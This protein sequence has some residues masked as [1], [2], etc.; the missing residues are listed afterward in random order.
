MPA[1]EEQNVSLNRTHAI[2]NPIGAGTDLL[3]G[4]ASRTTVA[5]QIPSWAFGADIGAP[6]S[7]ILA[8]VP[9]NKIR[10]YLGHGAKSGEFARSARTLQ[11]TREHLFEL[12]PFKTVRQSPGDLLSVRGEWEIGKSGVLA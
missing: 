7:F 8:I 3:R 12:Q 1:G 6:A 11:R 5:K 4:F 10:I 9:F 2:Y